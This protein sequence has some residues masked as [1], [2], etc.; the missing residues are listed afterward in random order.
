MKPVPTVE[1]MME[2][3]P[4]I[5]DLEMPVRDV[6]EIFTKKNIQ[7][8]GV[9][10]SEERYQGIVSTQGLMVAL[11][12]FVY[13]EVPPG[14]VK[15]YLDPETPTLS[16]K[17]TLMTVAE[18]FA[19]TGNDHPVLP[20]LRDGRLVGL[21]TRLDVI[22]AVMDYFASAKQNRSETLYISALR[23]NDEKPPPLVHL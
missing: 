3:V 15:S 18:R 11:V 14:P 13:D 19:R 7:C 6:A 4:A 17:Q 9:V 10:D 21:V 22:R 2:R 12:D 23:E 16:E 5:V 8:I 1:K 20:V